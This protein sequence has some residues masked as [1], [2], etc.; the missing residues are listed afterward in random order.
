MSPQRR[1][2]LLA[3]KPES[4]RRYAHPE[5]LPRSETKTLLGSAA[6]RCAETRACAGEAHHH[7]INSLLRCDS[8]LQFLACLDASYEPTGIFGLSRSRRSPRARR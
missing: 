2:N 4:L 3:R 5:A 6:E 7:F 1:R 8:V